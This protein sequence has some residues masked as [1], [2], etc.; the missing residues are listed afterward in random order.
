MAYVEPAL[1]APGTELTVDVRG[2]REPARVVKLPFYK[3]PRRASQ[4]G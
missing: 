4:S 1:T 2:H 3:R